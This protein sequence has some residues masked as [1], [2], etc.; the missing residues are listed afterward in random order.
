MDA[1]DAVPDP[2]AN[3]VTESLMPFKKKKDKQSSN[4]IIT[5]RIIVEEKIIFDNG[6][7]KLVGPQGKWGSAILIAA[8][9]WKKGECTPAFP[10]AQWKKR[11][12]SEMEGNS[13]R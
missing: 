9:F 5:Q 1:K 10:D 7:I 2:P 8:N 11:K 6:E 3:E 12:E 4:V 13:A